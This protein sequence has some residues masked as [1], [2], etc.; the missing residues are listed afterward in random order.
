[1]HY[2]KIVQVT[3]RDCSYNDTQDAIPALIDL[4]TLGFVIAETTEYLSIAKEQQIEAMSY[5]HLTTIPKSGIL[6]IKELRSKGKSHASV[7]K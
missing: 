3:W 5:R 2:P 4:C 1:M 7:K 6:E